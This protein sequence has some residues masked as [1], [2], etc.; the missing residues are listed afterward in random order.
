MNPTNEERA[1]L[2]DDFHLYALNCLKIRDK[3]G[4]ITSFTFNS[5]QEYLHKIV[6]KQLSDTGKVRVIILKGRQQGISTYIEGRGYWKVAH[7]RGRRAFILTHEAEATKNL[8]EMAKRY[9]ENCPLAFRPKTGSSSEKELHFEL[10]DSGYRVGTA[11]NKNTG[12]SSTFQFFHGSEAAFWDN[13]QDIAKGA[14]QAVPDSDDTEVYIESTANGKLNWFYEQWMLAQSGESDYVPVFIP[15]FWQ[16]E[17]RSKPSEK[18]VTTNEEMDLM[19]RYDLDFQQLAWRRKKISELSSS[20]LRGEDEF[21]QEYPSTWEEAFEASTLGL[22]L[23]K[24]NRKQHMVR[25]FSIPNHWTKFIAMDWGTAKPFSVGWYAVTDEDTVIKGNDTWEE[26]L[27]PKGALIRYREFYGWNGQPDVGC[28]IESPEVARRILEIEEETE[29]DID[30]RIGDSAMWGQHDGMSVAERMMR[31]TDGLFRMRQS[32]KGREQNYQEIR[33]RIQ[34]D[35]D[36][37]P[38]LYALEGCKHFWRTLPSLQLDE[39]HPEKGPD[40]K[41]EDHIYDELS[42]ACASR[43]YVTTKDDRII[44]ERAEMISSIKRAASKYKK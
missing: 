15:W 22:A 14:L 6:T 43:P 29:E 5:A 33:A 13:S 18:M 19:K 24:L 9:H 20:G 30:Y 40:S 41:Q 36:G 26:K 32:R 7:S 2:R 11:G 3:A 12:R 35:K 44:D 17:Y 38:M 8:F 34:G 25:N 31:E 1:L 37:R 23:E 27:L 10:L 21:R 28:R 16:Q 42:Y 39:S 4:K